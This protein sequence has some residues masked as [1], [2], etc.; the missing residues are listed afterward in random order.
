MVLTL[1]PVVVLGLVRAVL[2]VC[3]QVQEVK[4]KVVVVATM[5]AL[6]MVVD[7]APVLALASILK[8]HLM[9]YSG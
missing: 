1:D 2:V 4:V 6:G 3:T 7:L 8:A 5:V 9:G